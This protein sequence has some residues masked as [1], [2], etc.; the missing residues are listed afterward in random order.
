MW[1]LTH[2]YIQHIIFVKLLYKSI[3]L[4]FFLGGEE[5]ANTKF[6][7]SICAW[8]MHPRPKSFV[9]LFDMIMKLDFFLTEN[10]LWYMKWLKNNLYRSKSKNNYFYVCVFMGDIGKFHCNEMFSE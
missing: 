7:I 3:H 4:L 1:L 6:I 9:P 8:N 10:K 5:G 2:D